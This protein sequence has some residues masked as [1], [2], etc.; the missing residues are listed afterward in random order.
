MKVTWGAVVA[1]GTSR[2]NLTGTWRTLT[3]EV[4]GDLCNGCGLCHWWCPD[5]AISIMDGK[6]VIDFNYC[7]GCGICAHE[8]SRKAINMK[9]QTEGSENR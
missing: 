9:A 3:P 1:P 6:C 4:S 2:S 5:A 7:K 8:C